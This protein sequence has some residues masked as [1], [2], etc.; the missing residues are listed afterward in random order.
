MSVSL[1]VMVYNIMTPVMPPIR[2]YGQRERAARVPEV[3]QLCERE[4]AVDILVLNEVIPGEIYDSVSRGL[5]SIGFIHQTTPFRDGTLMGSSGVVVLSRHRI[6]QTQHIF[7]GST[8]AGIDC[9]CSKGVLYVR[10]LVDNGSRA[11]NV[12]GTHMQAWPTAEGH[13]VRRKQ[14]EVI[15][16]FMDQIRIPDRE[17]II[18]CGDLNMDLF[19]NNAELKHLM[20]RLNMDMPEIDKH[21]NPYTVDPKINILVGSDDPQAYANAEYPLGCA[22]EYLETLACPCCPSEW[23]DYV[24]VSKRGLVPISSKI[25]SVVVKVPEFDMH[26]GSTIRVKSKDVSDHFPVVAT[27]VF[28]YNSRQSDPRRVQISSDFHVHAN[29]TLGFI[30]IVISAAILILIVCGIVRITRFA[31]NK[32]FPWYKRK[33]NDV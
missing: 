16:R 2:F 5:R 6:S 28:N 29:Y 20:F 18:L 31:K 23:L 14:V 19:T 33:L 21:S 9:L 17:P 25:T 4:T 3:V 30:L 12:F 8:C 13:D 11:V 27:L 15:R 1:R 24:L 26:L 7:F 10:V 32:H 22:Q